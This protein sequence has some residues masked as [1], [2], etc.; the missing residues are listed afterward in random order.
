MKYVPP[1]SGEFT[2]LGEKQMITKQCAK[3]YAWDAINVQR[4]D[5]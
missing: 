2:A 1:V 5:N 3:C 4:R